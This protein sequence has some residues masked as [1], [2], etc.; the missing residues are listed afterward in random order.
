MKKFKKAISLLLIIGML[1]ISF[2]MSIFARSEN[3]E[4]SIELKNSNTLEVVED[5][6]K[7]YI[8]VDESDDYRN[9]Y[10]KSEEGN[11]IGEFRFDKISGQLYSSFANKVFELENEYKEDSNGFGLYTKTFSSLDCDPN[12][13]YYRAPSRITYYQMLDFVGKAVTAAN[14]AAA[15]VAYVGI[16]IGEVLKGVTEGVGYYID[17]KQNENEAYLK[18]HGLKF[19]Y[20]GYCRYNHRAERYIELYNVVDVDSY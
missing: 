6:V 15:I 16:P 12:G 17:L 1:I 14:I 13:S 9:V 10:V 20:K 2:P 7:K 3:E 4:L 19:Y 18:R 11:I 8:E 5:G